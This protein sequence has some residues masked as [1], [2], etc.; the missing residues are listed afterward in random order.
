MTVGTKDGID[1]RPLVVTAKNA[2]VAVHQTAEI[3]RMSSNLDEAA[4]PYL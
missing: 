1:L 4:Q 2:T 3:D